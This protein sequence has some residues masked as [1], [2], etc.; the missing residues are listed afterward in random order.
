MFNLT[1][2]SNHCQIFFLSLRASVYLIHTSG[3]FSL[4][5]TSSVS[6][7]SIIHFTQSFERLDKD[8]VMWDKP[9]ITDKRLK[10]WPVILPVWQSGSA[11]A[12]RNTAS[13]ILSNM[14][15]L[16][17]TLNILFITYPVIM[18]YNIILLIYNIQYTMLICL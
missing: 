11:T 9:T 17:M 6:N 13:R 3:L 10:Q 5:R 8:K 1:S 4:D 2:T 7:Y 12:R 18:L 16:A 15:E 14:M